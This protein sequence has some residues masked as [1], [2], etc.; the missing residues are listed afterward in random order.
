MKVHFE[1]WVEMPEAAAGRDVDA[2]RAKIADGIHQGIKNAWPQTFLRM[3]VQVA[4]PAA[5]PGPLEE[6]TTAAKPS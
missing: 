6:M 4:K 5:A 1:G 3:N 2:M